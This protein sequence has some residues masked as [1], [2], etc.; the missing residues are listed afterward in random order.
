MKGRAFK[1]CHGRHEYHPKI[2]GLLHLLQR[3]ATHLQHTLPWVSGETQYLGIFSAGFYSCL[4]PRSSKSIKCML[5]TLFRRWCQMVH[6]KQTVDLTAPNS[7]TLVDSVR[8][9]YPVHI[10]FGE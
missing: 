7:D 10:D 4:V 8:T 1:L 5:K 3:I 6:K 2:L 9:V